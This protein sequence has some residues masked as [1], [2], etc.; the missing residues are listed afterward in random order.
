MADFFPEGAVI[1]RVSIEPALMLGAGR[2]LLLQLAHAPVAQGV[3]DH[4]DF[5]GNPFRRLLGTLEAT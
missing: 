2:A 3:Q 1:R 5:R 4:S